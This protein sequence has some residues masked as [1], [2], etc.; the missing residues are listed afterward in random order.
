MDLFFADSKRDKE[1]RAA[2]EIY[3]S[4]QSEV[5]IYREFEEQL[6][7]GIAFMKASEKELRQQNID[8]EQ[9]SKELNGKTQATANRI[10][11]MYNN[12]DVLGVRKRSFEII[13]AFLFPKKVK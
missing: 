11:E 6:S 3:C 5:T 2:K 13:E 1:I 9:R 7:D 10:V 4:F 8:I 12:N